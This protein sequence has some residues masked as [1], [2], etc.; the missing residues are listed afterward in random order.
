MFYHSISLT[1]L[2]LSNFDI[3]NVINMEYM[4]YYCNSLNYINIGSFIISQ[5]SIYLFY[6]LPDKCTII[7]NRQSSN[8]I[9]TIPNTSNIIYYD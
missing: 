9:K 3:K 6:N 1:S 8:K 5:S 4:F 7:I 2:D